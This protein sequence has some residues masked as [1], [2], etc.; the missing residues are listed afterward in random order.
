MHAQPYCLHP[1]LRE[2]VHVHSSTCF[3]DYQLP[4]GGVVMTKKIGLTNQLI[5]ALPLSEQRDVMAVS[6]QISLSFEQILRARD[7]A[8]QHVYFPTTAFISEL[9]VT[10][11]DECIEVRLVGNEGMLGLNLVLGDKH[12]PFHAV[13]QGKGEALRL[14]R[15]DFLRVLKNTPKLERL[16]HRYTYVVMKQMAQNI[17]C[18]QFHTIEARLARWLLMTQDRAGNDSFPVTQEFLSHMLGA[19]RVGITSAAS[20]LKKNKLIHYVRGEMHIIDREGLRRCSCSCYN[21]D[22]DNYKVHIHKIKDLHV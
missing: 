20:N 8:V 15:K 13:V 21:A 9:V 6:E 1:F 17:A 18:T 3:D 10:D 19:S 2:T 7:E 14:N 22:I 11:Q 5:S 12:A 16:L 4:R